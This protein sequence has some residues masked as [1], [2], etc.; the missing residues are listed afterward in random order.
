MYY[1]YSNVDLR[2]AIKNI[3]VPALVLLE[4][5]FKKIAPIVEQQFGNQPNFRLE[6][7]GKGLHFIMF[8]DWEWYIQQIMGFINNWFLSEIVINGFVKEETRKENEP[9]EQYIQFA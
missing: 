7:A 1:D 6:Y 3:S 5:P 2:P 8:D 9:M 4:H